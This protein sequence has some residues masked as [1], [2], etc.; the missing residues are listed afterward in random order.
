M[1]GAG[2]AA[3]PAAKRSRGLPRAPGWTDC[4]RELALRTPSRLG[5]PDGPDIAVGERSQ[6]APARP[7]PRPQA[8]AYLRVSS[9]SQ[10]ESDKTSLQEQALSVSTYCEKAGLELVQTYSDI[11]SGTSRQRPEWLRMLAAAK[12][13]NFEHLVAW[14]ADR[15]ARGGG[16]MS[17]LLDAAPASKVTIHTANGMIFDRRY[18]ELLAAVAKIERQFSGEGAD[19]ETRPGQSRAIADRTRAIRLRSGADDGKPTGL[20]EIDPGTGPVVERIFRLSTEAKGVR[21]IA[22]ALNA[23]GVESPS[24]S[25]WWPGGI[26]RVLADRA[27]IGVFSYGTRRAQG[28]TDDAIEVAIPALVDVG[29]FNAVQKGKSKRSKGFGKRRHVYAL[30]GLLTC[31]VCE[32]P[33]GGTA[34]VSGHG[35][36]LEKPRRYYRCAADKDSRR[37]NCRTKSHQPAAD[38]EGVVRDAVTQMLADPYSFCDAF[39]EDS[40]KDDGVDAEIGDAERVLKDLE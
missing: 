17:D 29:L 31:G 24:G 21:A 14:N 33:M 19:R 35:K 39:L 13:G 1:E 8:V 27:Y 16:P 12:A 28:R 4:G 30:S 2:E 7:K 26:S 34:V 15:L 40:L 5:F 32:R 22:H 11:A 36:K 6:P 10:A 38:I 23:E 25:H 9:A 3:V 20:L 18:A 37:P